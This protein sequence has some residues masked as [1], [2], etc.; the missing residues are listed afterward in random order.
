MRVQATEDKWRN[1]GTKSL[2]INIHQIIKMQLDMKLQTGY[3]FFTQAYGLSLFEK[4]EFSQI[5]S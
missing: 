2:E 1:I 3:S 4:A 5:F